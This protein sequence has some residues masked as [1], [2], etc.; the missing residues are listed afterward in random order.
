MQKHAVTIRG[1]RTSISLEPEFWAEI[2]RLAATQGKSLAALI[3]EIDTARGARVESSKG[4]QDHP[5]GGGGLSSAIRVYVLRQLH[6]A[7]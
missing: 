3:A 1:H 5:A 7:K 6:G 2:K 4:G